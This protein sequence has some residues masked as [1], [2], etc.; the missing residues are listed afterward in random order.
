MILT[1][2]DPMMETDA[3]RVISNSEC[4]SAAWRALWLRLLSKERKETRQSKKT[5]DEQK[6]NEESRA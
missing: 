5:A 2:S 4:R 6:Q 1:E 3:Q